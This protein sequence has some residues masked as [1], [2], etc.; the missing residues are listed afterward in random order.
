MAIALTHS[1]TSVYSSDAPSRELL[2]GT[3]DGIVAL[4][5]A[6]QSG[7]WQVAARALAGK[8]IS[9]I[10]FPTPDLVLAAIYHGGI[11]LSRDRGRNWEPRDRGIAHND[12]Y[13]LGATSP[14]GKL[15]LFAGT[16]PA[17]FYISD[18]L[19][20][21]W[22]ESPSLRAGKGVARWTFPGPPHKAHVKVITVAPDD[23]KTIYASIEQ[24]DLLRSTDAGESWQEIAGFEEGFD[25]D[26]HRLVIHPKTPSR[27]Y[28]M[29]GTG[30]CVSDDRGA[31]WQRYTGDKSPIGGYPDQLTYLPSQPDLLVASGARGNPLTWFQTGFA[32]SRI[33]LSR[34]R[35]KSWQ[36]L[37]GGLPSPEEWR[38]AIE[39]MTLEEHGG[40][41]SAFVGTTSGEVFA[42]DDS[43]ESW[44]LIASGIGPISKGMHYAVL[45]RAA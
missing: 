27:L 29:G 15:R 36:I 8:H 39:A 38:S 24:G 7:S 22:R 3:A 37:R 16:E 19:G 5:R 32:G 11:V 18:D 41:F 34:D 25:Y 42:S 14:G 13:S 4:E 35:G 44:S 28:M 40:S 31:S 43:G 23:P 26:V 10:I 12:V 45:N 21:N 9:S 20:E 30:L 1:G 33:G 2:V 17:H 6:A